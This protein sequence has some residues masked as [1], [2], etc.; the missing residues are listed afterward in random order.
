MRAF[1]ALAASEPAPT[2]R[3]Y[4]RVRLVDTY[5]RRLGASVQQAAYEY[6][7][8]AIRGLRQPLPRSTIPENSYRSAATITIISR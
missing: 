6:H 1:A 8:T 3:S 2:W 7:D 4:L 5:A